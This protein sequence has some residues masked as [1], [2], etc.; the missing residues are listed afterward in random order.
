MAS[1]NDL[2][3]GVV[4]RTCLRDGRGGSPTAVVDE[5]GSPTSGVAFTDADRRRVPVGMGTSHAVF[6]R[7]A[8]D[9]VVEL[10]FFTAEGELPACGHGTMAAVA[11]LAARRSGVEHEFRLRVSGRTF[12]G[13]A[14]RDGDLIHAAF[15]PGPVAVREA[16]AVEV[17]LVADAL[18]VAGGG[19][20]VGA[21]VAS[22]G[23]ARMLVPV[24]TPETV[25]AL[26]P[27]SRRLRAVCDRLGLL[28][29]YVYAVPSGSGPVVARMFAPSIGVVE[30]IANVNSTACLAAR[31]AGAGEV[32]LTVDMGDAVGEP[33]TI[34]ASVRQGVGGS[35]VL[36]GGMVTVV[37]GG[38][39]APG[40]GAVPD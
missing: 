16:G 32:G 8:A 2:A 24:G 36:V 1:E 11:F 28:G 3:R 25:W 26:S 7:C 39:G 14:V 27:D 17:G 22:L 20:R 18:G 19:R 33:A 21:C 23:R 34:T 12:V 31:L 4:V 30:D 10:R 38:V 35:R 29:C 6:V 5:G 9:G 13:R 40:A 37:R 15:D